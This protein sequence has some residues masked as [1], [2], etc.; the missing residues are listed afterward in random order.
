MRPKHSTAVLSHN[1]ESI[2]SGSFS[3][4]ISSGSFFGPLFSCDNAL[5]DTRDP[6]GSRKRPAREKGFLQRMATI[7]LDVVGDSG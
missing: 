3:R 5:Y 2:S 6:E 1:P 4:S 7:P